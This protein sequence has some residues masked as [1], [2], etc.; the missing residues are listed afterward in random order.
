M[1]S[2]SSEDDNLE[3]ESLPESE[4]KRET[5]EST[6]KKPQTK[7]QKIDIRKMGKI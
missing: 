1:D 4:E 5:K 2:S 3:R 6:I 7:K